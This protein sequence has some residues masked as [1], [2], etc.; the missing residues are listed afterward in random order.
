MTFRILAGF[1]SCNKF[2]PTSKL[3]VQLLKDIV[4]QSGILRFG[5]FKCPLD[6]RLFVGYYRDFS[7]VILLLL[8]VSLVEEVDQKRERGLGVR[9]Q[10]TSVDEQRPDDQ[11]QERRTQMERHSNVA[12]SVHAE[13]WSSIGVCRLFISYTWLVVRGF[14]FP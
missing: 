9:G 8:R 3:L 14:K 6:S 4:Q 12:Q 1:V 2:V 13:F 7:N 10:S 5:H 11:Q